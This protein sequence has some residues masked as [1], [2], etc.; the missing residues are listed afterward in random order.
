MFP[1]YPLPSHHGVSEVVFLTPEL[2]ISHLLSFEILHYVQLRALIAYLD[3]YFPWLSAAHKTRAHFL[4]S[5]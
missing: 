3:K 1:S 5:F 4:I 2:S